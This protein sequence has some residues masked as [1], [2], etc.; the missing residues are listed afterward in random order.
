VTPESC[1][2]AALPRKFVFGQAA[3]LFPLC[4]SRHLSQD[5]IPTKIAVVGEQN[6]WIS[7]LRNCTE[8]RQGVTVQN[9]TVP[10]RLILI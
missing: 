4:R 1:E 9:G 5:G 10:Y 8:F 7:F 6:S 3:S 2:L